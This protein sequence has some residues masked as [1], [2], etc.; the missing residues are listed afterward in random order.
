MYLTLR[1]GISG[2]G[3]S[4]ENVR[5][6]RPS[7]TSREACIIFLLE[8]NGLLHKKKI[9]LLLWSLIRKEK[10]MTLGGFHPFGAGFFFL[11]F[12]FT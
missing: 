5:I 2:T 6:P 11:L 10:K 4:G 8:K 1:S 3:T 12:F 7:H 9:K